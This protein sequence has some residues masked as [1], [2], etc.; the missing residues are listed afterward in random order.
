MRC[1]LRFRYW[2]WQVNSAIENDN[3]L[4]NYLFFPKYFS[5][6]VTNFLVPNFYFHVHFF[7]VAGKFKLNLYWKVA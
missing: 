2:L 6:D 1:P 7:K 3:G 5:D 4:I